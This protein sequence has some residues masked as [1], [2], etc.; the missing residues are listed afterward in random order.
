MGDA[1]PSPSTLP[2]IYAAFNSE[3]DG[4]KSA[5]SFALGNVTGGNLAAYLPQL[6]KEVNAQNDKQYV[7]LSLSVCP[8]MFQ[9]LYTCLCVA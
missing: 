3:K 7:S 6:I 2:T 4:V 8:C 9:H 1:L 5:A